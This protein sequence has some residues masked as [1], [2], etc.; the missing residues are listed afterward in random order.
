M[1]QAVGE[2]RE[3]A[4]RMKLG[5]VVQAWEAGIDRIFRGAPAVVVTHAP[6]TA[7]L[8]KEDCVIALTYL[9][10]AAFSLG[11]GTCWLGYLM[12]A[13]KDHPPLKQAL[14]LPPGHEIHGA[15]IIGHPRYG[16]HRLPP[17]EEIK[18]AWL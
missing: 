6:G 5:K 13:G 1:R 16:Y 14:R 7:S 4:V 8:P 15:M 3:V 12:L 18:A 10:L 11:L 9:D 17:R 2:G